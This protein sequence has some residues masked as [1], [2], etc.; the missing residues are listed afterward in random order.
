MQSAHRPK[1][2]LPLKEKGRSPGNHTRRAAFVFSNDPGGAWVRLRQAGFEGVFR[3]AGELL[4]LRGL[5]L[6]NAK[7]GK[8]WARPPVVTARY[9]GEVRPWPSQCPAGVAR[10][11]ARPA[12]VSRK[13]APRPRCSAP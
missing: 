8:G 7:V 4:P 1:P 9:R 11:G 5:R 10:P 13:P 2:Q 3:D 12:A 6:A